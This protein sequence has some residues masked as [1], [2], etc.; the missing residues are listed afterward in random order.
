MAVG[1]CAHGG[2]GMCIDCSGVVR[3]DSPDE[4]AALVRGTAQYR[5]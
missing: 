3:S 5:R 2:Q 4:F 1:G